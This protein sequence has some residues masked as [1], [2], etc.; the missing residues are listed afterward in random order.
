MRRFRKTTNI[1]GAGAGFTLFELLIVVGIM[2]LV[3]GFAIAS[4]N[5]FN[6]RERLQQAALNL[7]SALRLAQSQAVS[8]EKPSLGCKTFVG[9]RVTF[10]IGVTSS[11][12]LQHECSDGDVGSVVTTILPSDV[13]YISSPLPF[14]FMALSRITSL[15]ADQNIQLTNTHE[16]YTIQ[17]TTNG[18]INDIGFSK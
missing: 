17:V 1:P 12:S 3:F 4:F 7:K 10:T 9:M 6:R 11:Y 15:A 16:T 5:T 8:A 18:E 2:V 14:T 13:T